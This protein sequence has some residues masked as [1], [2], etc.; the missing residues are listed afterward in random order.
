MLFKKTDMYHRG[1]IYYCDFTDIGGSVQSG[2]RPALIIQNDVGNRNSTTIIVSPITSIIK[3]PNLPTHVVIGKKFGLEEESMV[4]LEQ[5][6]TID[7]SIHLKEYIG[8]VTDD[9]ILSRINQAIRVSVIGFPI[10][11]LSNDNKTKGTVVGISSMK[12]TMLSSMGRA[13]NKVEV[14]ENEK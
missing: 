12:K 8:T 5:I 11:K 4:M 10:S 3:K 6:I 2:L 1:D 7:K 9:E 13:E 14:E